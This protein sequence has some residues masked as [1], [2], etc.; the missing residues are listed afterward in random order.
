LVVEW[1]EFRHGGS[2]YDLSHLRPFT[3]S[4]ERAATDEH[5]AESFSLNISF[6]HHCFTRGL[7]ADGRTD[8]PSLRFDVD[9]DRRIF[10][11]RRWRLSK[12]LPGII[13]SLAVR[14][15][16]QTGHSNFLTVALLDED[17]TR[18]EYDVFFR[19][20]KPGRGRLNLYVESAYVRDEADKKNR[21]RGRA[22]GFFVILHNKRHDRTIH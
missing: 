3:S 8:D 21:P 12:H 16:R 15:C 4:F 1:K 5:A 10:D 11:E 18:I 13:S 22:I 14:K 6:S 20:W 17:G 19:V 9:G 2:T 7:P